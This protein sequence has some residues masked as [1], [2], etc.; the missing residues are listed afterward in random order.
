MLN[1]NLSQV[2]VTV[3]VTLENGKVSI[4]QPWELKRYKSLIKG[5]FPVGKDNRLILDWED[6]QE[7]E[8][9]SL[10]RIMITNKKVIIEKNRAV[11]KYI[12]YIILSEVEEDSFSSNEIVLSSSEVVKY[13]Y[14][15]YVVSR[16]SFY[17][18]AIPSSSYVVLAKSKR[19]L[20]LDITVSGNVEMHT[21]GYI[22]YK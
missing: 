1:L 20:I 18:G 15:Y 14:Y 21:M 19:E 5:F 4:Y 9:L 12:P 3:E 17:T 16:H 8:R 10:P 6:H 13:G 2:D 22:K 11:C 7:E